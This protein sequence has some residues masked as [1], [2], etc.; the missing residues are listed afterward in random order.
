VLK[1]MGDATVLPDIQHMVEAMV[2]GICE[3]MIDFT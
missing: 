1:E 3:N 2:E